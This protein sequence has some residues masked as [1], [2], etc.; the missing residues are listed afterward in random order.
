MIPKCFIPYCKNNADFYIQAI[1]IFDA[2]DTIDIIIIGLGLAPLKPICKGHNEYIEW[3][4][5]IY[6]IYKK[7]VDE[8][9]K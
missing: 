1:N 7:P 6:N 3:G 4:R 5:K 2:E 9:R 8:V